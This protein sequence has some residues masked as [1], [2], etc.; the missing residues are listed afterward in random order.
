LLDKEK[1]NGANFTDWYRNLRIV[2]WQE[3][4]EY[5]LIELYPDK[6]PA[7]LTVVDHRAREKR[8]DDVL[9][10][11]DLMLATMSPDL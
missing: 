2:L 9:N 8:C 4:I 6:L 5:V 1:L 10:V 11:S 7:S 3:K